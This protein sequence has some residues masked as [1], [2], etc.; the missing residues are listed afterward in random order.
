MAQRAE[1]ASVSTDPD[2]ANCCDAR[3]FNATRRYQNA[4]VT[5]IK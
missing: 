5:G 2:L 1:F 3:G 4:D